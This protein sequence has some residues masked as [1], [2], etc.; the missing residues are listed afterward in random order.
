MRRDE[1]RLLYETEER[2]WWCRSRRRL[3]RRTIER[4]GWR[5]RRILDVACACGMNHVEY[6]RDA[7]LVGID[8]S[9][10]S[11]RFCR[12]RGY[13]PLV[14]SDAL[15][16][17]FLG[18]QFD[19]VLAIDALEHFSDEDRALREFARILRPGGWLAL[20]LPAHRILWSP[21]DEAVGHRRRYE[22]Q[23]LHRLLLR[24][25]FL[26]RRIGYW[27][28]VLFLPLLAWRRLR[29]RRDRGNSPR[30]DFHY[31]LPRPAS[32]LLESLLAVESGLLFGRS[33]PPFGTS[34]LALATRGGE[35]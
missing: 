13:G 3:V 31:P 14:R 22:A 26:P 32:A 8:I 27:G 6:G 16:L 23:P 1:Y 33:A 25:G 20:N 18:G 4:A 35:P 7:R 5:G 2:H 29:R 28:T 10:E 19:G 12:R 24:H 17:P 34:L 30:S 9:A 15:R 11:L 21:H